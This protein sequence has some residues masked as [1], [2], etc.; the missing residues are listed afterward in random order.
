MSIT[1][2]PEMSEIV[3]Y[4]L[5]DQMGGRSERIG[6][7]DSAIAAL[8]DM[9]RTG[10]LL[11]G[12]TDP[13][14]ARIWGPQLEIETA[15]SGEEPSANFSNH[16]AVRLLE[17]LGF[18][19]GNGDDA[20]ESS[21]ECPAE[22]FLGRVMVAQAIA[23]SDEGVPSY[24]MAGAPRWIEGGRRAGYTESALDSLREVAEWALKSER[25]VCWG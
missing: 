12:C 18:A 21:G 6:D 25:T 14:E 17:L 23:P 7:Y 24:E 11:P 2:A 5:T 1:F 19:S 22:D 13:E 9:Q 3:G 4:R 8:E 20:V 16:N 10:A 15:D